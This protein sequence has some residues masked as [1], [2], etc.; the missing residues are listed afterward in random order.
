MQNSLNIFISIYALLSLEVLGEEMFAIITHGSDAIHN[1]LY[2][3]RLP[4]K[5]CD[6]SL[7][8]FADFKPHHTHHSTA[9]KSPKWLVR[10]CTAWRWSRWK[11]TGKLVVLTKSRCLLESEYRLVCSYESSY[12]DFTGLVAPEWFPLWG[13]QRVFD[14]INKCC[15]GVVWMFFIIVLVYY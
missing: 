11:Q 3:R 15:V 13:A 7:R 4:K 8:A 5:L 12:N 14:F 6:F 1:C 2:L 9:K 10:R